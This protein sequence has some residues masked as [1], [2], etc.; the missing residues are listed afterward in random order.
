MNRMLK[1]VALFVRRSLPVVSGC[2]F[3]VSRGRIDPQRHTRNKELENPHSRYA[4]RDTAFAL[5]DFF[6]IL[7]RDDV[8]HKIVQGCIGDFDLDECSRCS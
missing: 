8:A 4:S 2:E 6:S 5:E 7:L 3:Q 1:K